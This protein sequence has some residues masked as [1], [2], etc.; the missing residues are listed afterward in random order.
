[1][2]PTDSVD[3][4]ANYFLSGVAGGDH[5]LKVGFKWRDDIAHTES[6]Y[7]GDAYA[8]F[9]NDVAAEA[10]LYRRGLTEYGLKNR[11][12]Y[13]QDTYTRKKTTVSLGLRFDY[14]TD[15]ANAADVSA[16]PFFGQ[17]TYAGVYNGVTYPGA[18]FNQLPALQFA[19]AD[20]GVAFK[21]WSPRV[22]VTYRPPRRRPQRRQVQLLAVRESARHGQPVEHLQYRRLDAGPVS[23]GGPQRRPVHPGQR[24]RADGRAA[25]LHE[26]V[27]LQRPDRH[28]DLRQ[29][30][31]EPDAGLHERDPAVVRQADWQR[32]RRER[33]LHLAQVLQL[34]LVADRQLQQRQLRGEDVHT[35]R[36]GLSGGSAV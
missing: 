3:V 18:V 27:Q 9:R 16:S 21:N 17:A 24:S 31:P 33:Q 11:N 12:F 5:A 30:G 13:V 25:Q 6:M 4:V 15:F 35:G 10:Q 28:L 29:G 32:V 2:R 22:G 23:V 20:A 14:Q 19:G 36:I 26:R 8:R 7:G 34:Q 1:M